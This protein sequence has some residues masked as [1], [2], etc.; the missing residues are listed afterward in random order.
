MPVEKSEGDNADVANKKPKYSMNSDNFNVFDYIE[1][2]KN[3]NTA[4]IILNALFNKTT[5]LMLARDV[6]AA[7]SVP[8]I[9]VVSNFFALQLHLKF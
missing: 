8:S 1:D 6:L 4:I 7:T 9:S 3:Y 2:C 5:S